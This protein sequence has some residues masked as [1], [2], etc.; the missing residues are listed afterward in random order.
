MKEQYYE[1]LNAALSVEKYNQTLS[2]NPY[3]KLLSCSK[4]SISNWN[5]IGALDENSS[6]E[7]TKKIVLLTQIHHLPMD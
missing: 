7:I 2:F 4:K 6:F 5:D 1:K 3:N